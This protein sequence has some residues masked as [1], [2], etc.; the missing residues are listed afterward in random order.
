MNVDSHEGIGSNSRSAKGKTGYD[1]CRFV[2]QKEQ[3]A[4]I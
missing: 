2:M 1:I 4:D 3:K